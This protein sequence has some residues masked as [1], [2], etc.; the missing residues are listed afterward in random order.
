[1]AG[2]KPGASAA[3][4]SLVFLVGAS[5]WLSGGKSLARNTDS[6]PQT[7]GV[8]D[9]VTQ[10]IRVED[11][12]ALASAKIRWQ[13]EKGQGLPV[14]FDPAVLTQNQLPCRYPQA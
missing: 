8:A 4:A 2:F 14:L 10:E 9:L 12:F 6:T 3:S 5:F 7:W 1:L 11:K 13:A